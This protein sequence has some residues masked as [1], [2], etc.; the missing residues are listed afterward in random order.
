MSKLAIIKDGTIHTINNGSDADLSNYVQSING[1]SGVINDGSSVTLSNTKN[2]LTSVVGVD[3]DGSQ[4]LVLDSSGKTLHSIIVN[5]DGVWVDGEKF[6]EQAQAP[7]TTPVR[8]I[9]TMP[10]DSTETILP[11]DINLSKIVRVYLN[12]LLQDVDDYDIIEDAGDIKLVF[13]S[14]LPADFKAT[15][16][17]YGSGGD[18]N[19]S[20]ITSLN[21][22]ELV[23]LDGHYI[24]PLGE[25]IISTLSG[26]ELETLDGHQ[27][28]A[29]GE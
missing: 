1:N 20:I 5:K 2:G 18:D 6:G 11:Y 13:P 17:Y 25:S 10:K 3:E 26:D 12:G 15:I 16:I 8:Y 21:G 27:W 24:V 22:D 4:L 14:A 29:L 7:T 9:V 28:A 23:T 19:D